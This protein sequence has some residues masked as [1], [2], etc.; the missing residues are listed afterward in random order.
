MTK[1]STHKLFLDTYRRKLAREPK[2]KPYVGRMFRLRKLDKID[3][4][5]GGMPAF[6]DGHRVLERGTEFGEVVVPMDETNTRIYVAT[7]SGIAVWISKNYLG[8]EMPLKKNE[9]QDSIEDI[10]IELM[11]LSIDLTKDTDMDNLANSLRALASRL[12]ELS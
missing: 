3:A 8:K 1:S 6:G 9:K 10:V 4:Y 11:D 7:L 12:R 2:F 5:C